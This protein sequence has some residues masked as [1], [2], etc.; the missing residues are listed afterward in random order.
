MIPEKSGDNP[1]MESTKGQNEENDDDE[2]IHN[3]IGK[4]TDDNHYGIIVDSNNGYHN[5]VNNHQ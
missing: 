4:A 1:T 5:N 3:H 2:E